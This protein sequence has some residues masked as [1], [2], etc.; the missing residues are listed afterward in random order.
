MAN[1]ISIIARKQL[2]EAY[3]IRELD[4]SST[5]EY[6]SELGEMLSQDP[7]TSDSMIAG[8]LSKSYFRARKD[9]NGVLHIYGCSESIILRGVMAIMKELFD[10]EPAEDVKEEV[11]EKDYDF[12]EEEEDE[13][14]GFAAPDYDPDE[15]FERDEMTPPDDDDDEWNELITRKSRLNKIKK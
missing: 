14:L 9:A 10:L 15:E 7:P 6:L 1:R 12:E 4:K 8:C 3:T 2:E 13:E 11:S 5:M